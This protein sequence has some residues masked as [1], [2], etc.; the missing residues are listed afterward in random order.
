M[1]AKRRPLS[2]I[3]QRRELNPIYMAVVKDLKFDPLM[4]IQRRNTT[5]QLLYGTKPFRI[6]ELIPPTAGAPS[7]DRMMSP[8]GRLWTEQEIQI[9]TALRYA[10][11]HYGP[12]V[13]FS[14][15][16]FLDTS[17]TSE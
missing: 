13:P 7:D 11:T 10:Q 15:T 3:A 12:P 8:N 1:A 9:A 16:S 17:P 14:P 5:S 6:V 4:R 2:V